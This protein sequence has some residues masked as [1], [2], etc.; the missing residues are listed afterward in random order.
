MSVRREA[1]AV[2]QIIELRATFALENGQAFDPYEIRRVQILKASTGEVLQAIGANDVERVE[3]GVYQVF[4]GPYAEPV[5]LNDRWLYTAFEGG[6]E[7]PRQFRVEVAAVA[8]NQDLPYT[9]QTLIDKFLFGIDLT[10]PLT[11]QPYPDSFFDHAIKYG[12]DA[13]AR[14][15]DIDILPTDYVGAKT[16]RQDYYLPDYIQCA[17]LKLDHRPVRQ[18]VS[19]KAIY[20]GSATPIADFPEAWWQLTIPE[21]ARFELIPAVGTLASYIGQHIPII[22]SMG[23]GVFPGLF[24]V[25]YRTGWADFSQ[26]PGDIMQAIGLIASLNALNVAGD[27]VAG[28][29]LA[30]KSVSIGGLSQSISTTNSSTNAGYGA[31][32]I[33]YEKELKRLLP[34]IKN[35]FHG[36]ALAVV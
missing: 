30:S 25:E 20:P 2:G 28:A 36:P 32:L 4:V 35:A 22:R 14:A 24:H 12:V 6:V 10:D 27:L 18:I 3:E 5:T 13:V 15:C 11:G 21:A 19:V 23:V 17:T 29:G 1:A 31:R 9:R 34:Q 33:Q 26:I 8:V 7:V 16:E